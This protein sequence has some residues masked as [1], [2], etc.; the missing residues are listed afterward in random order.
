MRAQSAK[1]HVQGVRRG[2]HLPAQS[3]KEP[4]QGVRRVEHLPARSDKEPVQG[5]RRGEHLPARSEKEHVQGVRRGR[6]LSAQPHQ[7]QVQDVQG[8]Q[9]R[10]DAARPRGALNVTGHWFFLEPIDHRFSNLVP[11]SLIVFHTHVCSEGATFPP[12]A[13]HAG[14][15]LVTS[16]VSV[17]ILV[18]TMFCI[19]QPRPRADPRRT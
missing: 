16:L 18:H 19:L 5:V 14:V 1:E 12:R 4:V 10:L 8:R 17:C 2:E 7:E 13:R 9:G 15:Q 6:H 11:I 3:A